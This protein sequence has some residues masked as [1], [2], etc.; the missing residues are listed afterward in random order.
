MQNKY[1]CFIIL[2]FLVFLTN[3]LY[4]QNRIENELILQL[5]TGVNIDNTLNSLRRNGIVTTGKIE[6]KKLSR[7]PYN[8]W[9][10]SLDR[11]I[12]PDAL[13]KIRTNSNV[14]NVQ[15][16]HTVSYRNTPDDS[17]FYKQW[18]L[19]NTGQTG[20]QNDADIDAD[21]AWDLTTGGISPSGD[22]IVICVVDNGIDTSHV[23]LMG[24][25]WKNYGEIRGNGIDDDGN[26]YVDDYL[27]WNTYLN[28]DY[29]SGGNHGTPVAGIIGAKGDNKIG[30]SGINRNVKLMILLN[31]DEEADIIGAYLYAL[32][33]R[34]LYNES[35]GK[36]GA[37]VVATNS[38]F[39]IDNA[40][41]EN[42]PIWCSI[43]DSLGVAGILN[44]GATTNNNTNVDE[45]GDMPSSCPGDYLLTVTNMDKYNQ[46]VN[47]AGYGIKSIDIGAYGKETYSLKNYGNYGSFGGTSAAT[48]HATGVAGLVYAYGSKLDELSHSN[49]SNAALMAK[50]AIIS[51]TVHNSTLEN[52]T[53]SEGVLNAFNALKEVDKYKSACPPPALVNIDSAGADLIKISWEQND[54]VSGYNILFKGENSN[55]KSINTFG[56]KAVLAGLVSCSRYHFKI[57]SVCSDTIVN[58]GYEFSSKTI[59]CCEKPEIINSAI[60]GDS[61][62]LKWKDVFAADDYT[63]KFKYWSDPIWQKTNN[64]QNQ[65]DL[66]LGHDC[67]NYTI[68]INSNCNDRQSKITSISTNK[69]NCDNC[70][71]HNYCQPNIDNDFEWIDEV[72][73]GNFSYQSGKDE[74]GYG[75]F[76]NAPA[77]TILK[78]EYFDFRVNISFSDAIYNDYIYAWI[79]FNRDS[80]FSADEIIVNERNENN[81]FVEKSVLVTNDFI[82]G[83]SNMRILLSAYEIE[84]PCDINAGNYG[85]Y[86]DYCIM[87]DT[88]KCDIENIKVDTLNIDTTSAMINWINSY[89]YEH[90]FLEMKNAD[91][92]ETYKPIT[93]IR[94]TFYTLTGL[95]KCTNY[96]LRLTPY[97]TPYT[98]NSFDTF[99]FKTHCADAIEY[100]NKNQVKVF[101]NPFDDLIYINADDAISQIEIF[102][103]LGNKVFTNK[104]SNSANIKL[105]VSNLFTE[106]I[107]F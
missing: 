105:D 97:C 72:K 13:N 20:G 8:F 92:N 59:G 86:E 95:E 23:D 61:L 28:N 49:P 52:I 75:K 24:N 91:L 46:K 51:S 22:T 79:D 45:Y 77:T 43:Y 53:V 62:H 76:N 9:K 88:T 33:M 17:L 7:S 64:S 100:L 37:F 65:F 35:N 106:G 30:I 58:T 60:S 82:Q 44:I 93:F 50:D 71:E 42:H 69:T 107:Y 73:I 57:Q 63:I 99:Q 68:K 32:K 96:T 4:G 56:H 94:D 47:G 48:P 55:W 85:E 21:L 2:F 84:N 12:L 27:G 81:F 25:L 67:G 19:N 39:G 14:V 18:S 74:F 29:I 70:E 3:S 40:K 26:G 78:G 104:Y 11:N 83:I 89:G 31:G 36:K 80:L 1:S 54:N 102:D 6:K 38:S 90:F 10:I 101:P 103:I 98:G 87:L 41:A 15:Y 16:N 5:K 34:K 66:E